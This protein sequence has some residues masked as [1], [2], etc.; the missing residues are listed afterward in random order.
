[1]ETVHEGVESH[2]CDLPLVGIVGGGA[3]PKA[4][5]GGWIDIIAG[6]PPATQATHSIPRPSRVV[7]AE[8]ADGRCVAL[9]IDSADELT[10]M[11]RSEPPLEGMPAGFT[12][13]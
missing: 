5:G 8:E 12:V 6:D 7:I 2:R 10:T 1:V 3:D 4:G 11:I 9:Q 13:V